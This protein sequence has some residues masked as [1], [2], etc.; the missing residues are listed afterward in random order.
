VGIR[1]ISRYLYYGNCPA[2][3]DRQNWF[4]GRFLVIDL[5]RPQSSTDW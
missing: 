3:G 2:I 4:L 5:L 1:S